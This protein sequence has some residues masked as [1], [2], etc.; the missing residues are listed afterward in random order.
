MTKFVFITG[1][2]GTG[3]STLAKEIAS[4]VEKNG[5]TVAE[6]NLDHY[7][8]PKKKSL[9]LN[10]QNFD[11]PE[12]IE[13]K[14]VIKH[15]TDLEKGVKIF[16]P[17]YEMSISDRVENGEVEFHPQDVIIV[18][19][20]FAADYAKY[21]TKGA[22]IFKIYIE[23]PRIKDNYTRKE[24]R[25]M[26]DRKQ[27]KD[28]IDLMKKNQISALFQFIATHATKS[29][30]VIKNVWLPKKKFISNLVSESIENLNAKDGSDCEPI[31]KNED[32]EKFIQFITIPSKTV[33]FK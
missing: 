6:F 27:S 23:S 5:F 31:L 32:L 9:E 7:Y 22:E 21:L 10:I 14:L 26:H 24:S 19:G 4:L 30:I 16:R 25:D 17:T 2:S 18:E 3:K 29:D 13:Q 8:L 11:V 33:V 1:S 12:A 15:L 20:I 28:H